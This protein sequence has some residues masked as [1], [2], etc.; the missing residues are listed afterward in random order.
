MND[1]T[2]KFINRR[3]ITVEDELI[4]SLLSRHG[5]ID[6]PLNKDSH[7]FEAGSESVAKN[8]EINSAHQDLASL[9]NILSQKNT[10][11]DDGILHFITFTAAYEE[12]DDYT[13]L[14][15]N[16]FSSLFKHK[17]LNKIFSGGKHKLSKSQEIGDKVLQYLLR[18]KSAEAIKY[19]LNAASELY[20]SVSVDFKHVYQLVIKYPA[21][22]RVLKSL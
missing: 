21:H 10:S 14:V 15:K 1:S 12:N 20:M 3:V 11:E 6:I 4:Y 5:G 8:D 18:T 13:T 16:K 7:N 2:S 9:L 22:R 19:F 17:I